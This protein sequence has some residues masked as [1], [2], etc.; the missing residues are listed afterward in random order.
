ME[1]EVY[2]RDRAAQ[3]QSSRV[4]R[5]HRVV[6]PIAFAAALVTPLVVF[7]LKAEA[8]RFQIVETVASGFGR[9][10]AAERRPVLPQ[11]TL[12]H[13]YYFR[14]MYLPQVTSGPSAVAWAPDGREVVVAMQGS[15]WRHRLGVRGASQIVWGAGYA[16]QPDWS[17]DDR[18]IA[19]A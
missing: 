10:P 11:I 3:R 1:A 5:T 12:P 8:T 6:V 9:T 18:Y 17:P 2:P 14:E 16:H 4:W 7:R 15:L 19:Y 13:D